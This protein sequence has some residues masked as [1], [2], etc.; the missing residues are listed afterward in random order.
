MSLN[1][2]YTH[3]ILHLNSRTFD[4][5][6]EEPGHKEKII[7]IITAFS[8]EVKGHFMSIKTAKK[9]QLP[10]LTPSHGISKV[11]LVVFLNSYNYSV[12]IPFDVHRLRTP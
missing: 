10:N 12:T 2:F 4:L 5:A 9:G 7:Y 8:T 6:Q 3:F 11:D 1:G